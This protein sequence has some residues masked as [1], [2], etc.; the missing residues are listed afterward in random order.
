MTTSTITVFFIRNRYV[1]RYRNRMNI[2]ITVIVCVN[3]DHYTKETN[4]ISSSAGL[5]INHMMRCKLC[6]YS[7]IR[8]IAKM[9]MY[10]L[11]ESQKKSAD[12]SIT[13]HLSYPYSLGGVHRSKNEI[14][15]PTHTFRE[16]WLTKSMY[17][18]I[19]DIFYVHSFPLKLVKSF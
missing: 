18:I 1:C 14:H 9:H 10:Q 15:K 7:R 17:L 3:N 6:V 4:P 11:F 12:R 5:K 2:T 19:T 8:C 13:E 16:E